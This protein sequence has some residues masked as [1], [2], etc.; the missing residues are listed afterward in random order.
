MTLRAPWAR[1]KNALLSLATCR[2]RLLIVSAEMVEAL[3]TL[4]GDG[5]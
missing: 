3:E 5:T 4:A 2:L 1:K